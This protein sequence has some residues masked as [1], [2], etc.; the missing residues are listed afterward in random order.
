MNGVILRS[1]DRIRLEGDFLFSY[2]FYTFLAFHLSTISNKIFTGAKM[3][4]HLLH[5]LSS[6]HFTPSHPINH[7]VTYDHFSELK[8]VP[9]KWD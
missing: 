1:L 6:L 2:L 3:Q 7:D 4:C 5:L 9:L 8:T